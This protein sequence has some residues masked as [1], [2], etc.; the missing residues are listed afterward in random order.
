MSMLSPYS[1]R[2]SHCICFNNCWQERWENS[3][4]KWSSFL[5]E[6]I[7]LSLFIIVEVYLFSNN[8]CHPQNKLP[9]SNMLWTRN[10]CHKIERLLNWILN[11]STNFKYFQDA[12]CSA[13]GNL[14]KVLLTNLWGGWSEE[15]SRK[16]FDKNFEI[17]ILYN[18]FSIVTGH[19]SCFGFRSSGCIQLTW[20]YIE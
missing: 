5:K 9:T 7:F 20:L 13:L 14:C 15:C 17:I 12:L 3:R 18:Y 2:F 19:S 8:S 16:P 4:N 11:Y 6:S 10:L 1:V